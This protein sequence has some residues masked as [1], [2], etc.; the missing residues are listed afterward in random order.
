MM[1]EQQRFLLIS[2]EPEFGEDLEP[3]D[4]LSYLQSKFV[5][6]IGEVEIIR[7]A[8][9]MRNRV[10]KLLSML[11]EKGSEV[12][13]HFHNAL[14]DSSYPHLAKLLTSGLSD[15]LSSNGIENESSSGNVQL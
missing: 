10:K 3:K 1:N 8:I 7:N 5:L 4:I 6:D 12:F 15:K 13:I 9:P 2:K 14:I 11:P